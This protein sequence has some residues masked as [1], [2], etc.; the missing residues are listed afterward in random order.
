MTSSHSSPALDRRAF[1]KSAA[2]VGFPISVPAFLFGVEGAPPS[3]RVVVG[4][5]GVGR[6]GGGHVAIFDDYGN[7]W[8]PWM[9]APSSWLLASAGRQIVGTEAARR[10]RHMYYEKP[11]ALTV[12]DA[13]AV[14]SAI[15]GAGIVLRSS[16]PV[17]IAAPPVSWSV[18]AELASCRRSS[19]APV[20]GVHPLEREGPPTRR[21]ASAGEESSAL[22]DGRQ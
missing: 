17:S 2:A 15:D 12:A 20:A 10:G 3:D 9:L 1:L 13:M 16:V 6:M 21:P 8:S 18:T 14:C 7:C 11:L 4:L 19:E 22:P 5:I